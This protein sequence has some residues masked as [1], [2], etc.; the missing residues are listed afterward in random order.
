M[1]IILEHA[2]DGPAQLVRH[3]EQNCSQDFELVLH[4]GGALYFE[5]L[6]LLLELADPH[7]TQLALLL[8]L[9]PHALELRHVDAREE[10]VRQPH[11]Q[12]LD[13]V[14]VLLEVRAHRP[15]ELDDNGLERVVDEFELGLHVRNRR[16]VA[17][18][19][20]AEH[21]DDA[22]ILALIAHQRAA[23]L[24][25][26]RHREAGILVEPGRILACVCAERAEAVL[27]GEAHAD[28][29]STANVPRGLSEHAHI[30]LGLLALL[31]RHPRRVRHRRAELGL[32]QRLAVPLHILGV[33]DRLYGECTEQPG[34]CLEVQRLFPLAGHPLPGG[35]GTAKWACP[36]LHKVAL[37]FHTLPHRGREP[38]T[39]FFFEKKK[40]RCNCHGTDL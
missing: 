5:R 20:A 32:V 26:A 27:L 19:L 33:R 16:V 23:T 13:R 24:G 22:S 9:G 25:K 2:L 38:L 1:R 30:R 10:L 40:S 14:L 12:L 6:G 39:N 21:G 28:V 34:R 35:G 29:V 15:D 18:L 8:V 4:E 3:V 11:E 31:L 17:L 7:L 37:P 36:I